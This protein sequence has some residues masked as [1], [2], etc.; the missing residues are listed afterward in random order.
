MDPRRTTEELEHKIRP[1]LEALARQSGADVVTLYA[2]DEESGQFFLPFGHGL[3]HEDSFLDPSLLPRPNRAAGRI[4][5][6]RRVVPVDRVVGHPEFDGAFTRR[7]KIE[8]AVGFPLCDKDRS[9]GVL[10]LSYRYHVQSFPEKALRKTTALRERLAETLARSD[11]SG[12]TPRSDGTRPDEERQS[13]Q[14][15]A[16]I[17]CS[18]MNVCT[19]IWLLDVDHE[20]LTI[21]ASSGLPSR[22]VEEAKARRGDGSLVARVL[23]FGAAST[24]S[25]FS[26]S[27]EFPDAESAEAAGW[28]ASVAFP[29]RAHD[30]VVGIWQV[31]LFDL[32]HLTYEH[33]H[34]LRRLA[35]LAGNNIENNIRAR[36]ADHLSRAARQLSAAPNMARAMRVV[37]DSAR[38]L[39]GA[40]SSSIVLRVRETDSFIIGAG[41]P[42]GWSSTSILPRRSGGLTRHIIDTGEIVRSDDASSHFKIKSATLDEGI[43]SLIGVRVQMAAEAIGVL[44]VHG[45]RPNQF[46]EAHETL[47]K[48]LADQAS[49]A[50]GWT[51]IVLEPAR[52]IEQATSRLFQREMVLDQVCRE[53]MED[54]GFDFAAIQLIR[55]EEGIIETAHATEPSDVLRGWARHPLSE[56]RSLRDIQ[57]DI[58]QTGRT[59]VIV[60]LDPRFD[61]WIFQ[62]FGHDQFV[63]VFTP[64]VLMR[65]ETGNIDHEWMD[66]AHWDRVEPNRDYQTPRYSLELRPSEIEAKQLTPEIIG[67]LEAGYTTLEGEIDLECAARFACQASRRAL[68][69]WSVLLPSVLET[70]VGQARSTMRADSAT[71]HFLYDPSGQRYSY[72]VAA[73]PVGRNFLKE[74]RP[75]EGGIGREA[76][77][78]NTTVF[79]P[80]PSRG[81]RED[82]LRTQHPRLFE[83]RVRAIAACP[84]KVVEGTQEGVLYIHYQRPHRFTE[85][86][87]GWVRLIADRAVDAIRHATFYVQAHDRTG[88]MNTLRKVEQSESDSPPESDLLRHIAWATLNVLAAD[89]VTIYEYDQRDDRWMT[90]PRI[91][92]RLLEEKAMRKDIHP[93]DVPVRVL[94]TGHSIYEAYS[95]DNAVLNDPNK[96]RTGGKPSFV[97]REKVE[98]SAAILLG[99]R[100]ENVGVMFI[101]YRRRHRFTDDDHQVIESLGSSAAIAIKNQRIPRG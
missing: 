94:T 77:E 52:Q 28:E 55:P 8:S 49:V 46:S 41:S 11:L 48:T 42:K 99:V 82:E 71:L 93:D 35:T 64:L 4:A 92:G 24:I 19:A 96:P 60:G 58:A 100:D 12:L 61:P 72:E 43:R 63:R 25:D 23:E 34:A 26:G 33:E 37:V 84:L 87:L 69:V 44:Y 2:Y 27:S 57:A 68:E 75:R 53:T 79:I 14:N 83:H 88:Q 80:N 62:E 47:L 17:A 90:P 30:G 74:F 66:E 54:F 7:E 86:E 5:R 98:S 81:H 40:E 6:E 85:E 39:T 89:V 13:L 70:I 29:I 3:F 76:I 50:L 101:N 31:L 20:T 36:W 56:T 97:R 38:K 10:F 15:I 91:A 65:N 21:A 22:L 32:A 45:H 78:S 51:R 9:V 1:Q 95:E 73:G 59:E 16:E 67:T 18:I